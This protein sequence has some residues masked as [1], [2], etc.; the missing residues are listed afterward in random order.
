MKGKTLMKVTGSMLV[1]AF[2]AAGC[3]DSISSNVPAYMEG[4]ATALFVVYDDSGSMEDRVANAQG[5]AESKCAIA[6]RALI[7]V[8]KR[9]DN[10]LA[11]NTNRALGVGI[12]LLRSGTTSFQSFQVLKSGVAKYFSDWT[13]HRGS[14]TGGTPLGHAMNLAAENMIKIQNVSN[15]H[16]LVLTDGMSNSGPAPDLVL[17]TIQQNFKKAGVDLGVHLVAFDV[18]EGIFSTLKS[19]GATVVGASNEVELNQKFDYILREKIMLE[20]EE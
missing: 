1:A 15:K 12:V 3:S 10:Y 18:N 4:Q 16:I 9:F 5:Q 2:L 14:P 7:A 20:K 19:Q 6:D 17:P 13:K 11:A 8:G